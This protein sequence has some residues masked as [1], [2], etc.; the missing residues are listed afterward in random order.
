MSQ[1]KTRARSHDSAQNRMRCRDADDQMTPRQEWTVA[2][3][4]AILSPERVQVG[5]PVDCLKNEGSG[6]PG[7]QTANQQDE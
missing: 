1:D 2:C 5:V 4:D 3:H 7:E 6:E